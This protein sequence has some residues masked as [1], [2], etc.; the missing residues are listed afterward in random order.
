MRTPHDAAEQTG[1]GCHEP[2]HQSPSTIPADEYIIGGPGC[3][4]CIASQEEPTRLTEEQRSGLERV[5]LAVDQKRRRA[6][7]SIGLDPAPPRVSFLYPTK[8]TEQ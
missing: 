3:P 4:M 2:H 8:E 1:N 7:R 5:L 6:W